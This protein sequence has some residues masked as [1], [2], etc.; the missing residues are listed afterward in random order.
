MRLIQNKYLPYWLLAILS[1]PLFF[2]NVYD[3]HAWGDDFAQYIK[4]AM[5]IAH[6]R[7]FYQSGWIYNPHNTEYAPPQYPPGYPLLL[8][9]VVGIW[10]LSLKAIAYF[11]SCIA[12]ALL[13]AL[14]GYFRKYAGITGAICVAVLITYSGV[15][16]DTKASILADMACLLFVT[17]YLT[18]RNTDRPD[19]KRILLLILLSAMAALTR[20]QALLLIVA[21]AMWLACTLL[22]S[23]ISYGH[24]RK[25]GTRASLFIIV[26]TLVL[27]FFL[28]KV[29]FYTP[30]KTGDFYGQ[31]VNKAFREPLLFTFKDNID[32]LINQLTLFFHYNAT[33][34]FLTVLG[35]V[36]ERAAITFIVLGFIISVTR[37]IAVDDM[38]FMLMGLL[39]I[40]LPIHDPRYLLPALP[41]AYYYVYAA[42]R[43]IVPVV[44]RV[45]TKLVAVL[46]TA[47]LLHTGWGYLL[48]CATTTR[49]E[50]MVPRPQERAAFSYIQQHVSDS[51]IIVFIKPRLLTLYTGKRTVNIAWQQ[52]QQ[53]C[54]TY[55]DSLGVKY[56]LILKGMEDKAFKEYVTQT[57]KA[58]SGTV[59][60]EDYILYTLR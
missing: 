51:D 45:N 21:E 13:F 10:D 15:L 54:K 6:G 55:F 20:S 18:Y 56:V 16:I 53:E 11:N 17:L 31:F 42:A 46:L 34:Y 39:V 3:V 48:R 41:I 19:S 5:N 50:G 60:A 7:P 52:T 47:L 14:Y 49:P 37:R 27:Y 32:R 28:D 38:F 25:P 8:A 26:G 9:P 44:T 57:Q 24:F 23:R 12:A 40:Y 22:K 30:L 2:L 58:I 1:V 35:S 4:E 43:A 33:D 36:A 59:I 29:V